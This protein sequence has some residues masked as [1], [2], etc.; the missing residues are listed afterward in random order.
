MPSDSPM[1]PFDDALRIALEHART[2]GT[3]RVP[4]YEATG[5]VLAEEVV[6]DRDVPPFDKSA[7]D[8]FACR[9]VDLGRELAVIETIPAGVMPS[10]TVGPGECAKIMTGAP[11]PDGADMVFV[12]EE[13][14]VVRDERVRFTG[15]ESR[16][17]IIPRAEDFTAGD[18]LLVPGVLL[19]P[20]HI[21]VLATAGVPEPLVGRRP[22][23]GVIATGD[24]LVEPGDIPGPSQIRNSNSH[25]LIA[26]VRSAGGAPTYF[27]IARDSRDAL[28]AAF[29]EAAAES[30]VL[31][32]SGGVSQGDFD[33]VP[34]VM[35]AHGAEIL[36][37]RVRIKPGK[38]ST[39]GVGQDLIC[40][41]MPGNPVSTFVIFEVL[42]RPFLLAMAGHTWAPQEWT[43]PLRAPITRHRDERDEWLPVVRTDDGGV[44]PVSYHGS[45]HF[46]ALARADGLTMVPAGTRLLPKGTDVRV[47]PLPT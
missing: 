25:Q 28:D 20:D 47:R 13:S 45:A 37:D 35:R 17:N 15:S 36:F 26:Q 9:R 38:P 5:R 34:D 27:G 3:E 2:T 39:L 14:E 19:R 24:E 29:S 41:G 31:L 11:A 46:L 33:F 44:L 4:L 32:F 6:A 23:V 40:F 1:L 16:N 12:V 21:A 43:A 42:V 7:M 8:G 18:R 22:R 10:K 30:D